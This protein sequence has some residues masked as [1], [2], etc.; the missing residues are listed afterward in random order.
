[1][2]A[3]S[4]LNSIETLLWQTLID[5]EISHEEIIAIFKEKDKYEK[6]KENVKNVSEKL[7]GKT[8]NMR[9]NSVKSRK[10]WVCNWYISLNSQKILSILCHQKNILCVCIQN[11][12]EAERLTKERKITTETYSKTKSPTICVQ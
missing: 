6:M 4:K 7:E 5:T 3:K 8:E 11:G 1:M 10:Y 2:F 9:L 12:S